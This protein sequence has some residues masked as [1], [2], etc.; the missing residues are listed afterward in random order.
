MPMPMMMNFISGR[1]GEFEQVP[2][3]ECLINSHAQVTLAR[4]QSSARAGKLGQARQAIWENRAARQLLKSSSDDFA[5]MASMLK[6]KQTKLGQKKGNLVWTNL[7][8]DQVGAGGTIFG[9]AIRR[10]LSVLLLF[11]TTGKYQS[12]AMKAKE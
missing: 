4:E 12:N 8:H 1:G 3:S 11:Y 5:Q 6:W 9:I 10:S 2:P 7:G